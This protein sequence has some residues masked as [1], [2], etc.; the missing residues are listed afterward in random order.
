MSHTHLNGFKNAQMFKCAFFYLCNFLPICD[1]STFLLASKVTGR[2]WLTAFPLYACW[3]FQA[4]NT[5]VVLI[6]FVTNM[7]MVLQKALLC[8]IIQSRIFIISSL[9]P[10]KSPMKS[11]CS[12]QIQYFMFT[13]KKWYNILMLDNMLY[14]MFTYRHFSYCILYTS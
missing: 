6:L 7:L 10:M 9:K 3:W 5:L 12:I 13:T 1:F 2:V 4:V 14:I 8:P 11:W